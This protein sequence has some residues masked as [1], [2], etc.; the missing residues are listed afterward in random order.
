MERKL[1]KLLGVRQFRKLVFGLERQIH[2]QDNEKNINYHLRWL[3]PDTLDTFTNY[4]FINVCIF[5][6][7]H[8][9]DYMMICIMGSIRRYSATARCS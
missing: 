4:I 8:N 9:A 1:Y 3:I 6:L 7:Q 5:D 2:R